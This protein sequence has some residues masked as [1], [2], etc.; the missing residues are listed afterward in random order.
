MARSK[1]LSKVNI[2][3]K[4][5][6]DLLVFKTMKMRLKNPKWNRWQ[7]T[8]L[9]KTGNSFFVTL[10]FYTW[11]FQVPLFWAVGNGILCQPL[12]IFLV[13]YKWFL[14]TLQSRNNLNKFFGSIEMVTLSFLML[15]KETYSKSVQISTT[16]L[17]T[18]LLIN[19]F[20]LLWFQRIKFMTSWK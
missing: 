20:N 8:L 18:K 4:W 13:L 12:T 3:K 17:F 19:G 1:S 15:Y 16:E 6:K 5:R 2:T 7:K 14:A 11:R 10:Y 9:H